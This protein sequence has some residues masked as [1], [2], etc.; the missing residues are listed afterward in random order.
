MGR[1]PGFISMSMARRSKRDRSTCREMK[2][3]VRLLGALSMS[4]IDDIFRVVA[5]LGYFTEQAI[6]NTKLHSSHKV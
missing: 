6:K 3:Q 2:G 5:R 1:G 4:A